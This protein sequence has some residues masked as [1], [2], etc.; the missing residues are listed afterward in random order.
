VIAAGCDGTDST[1]PNVVGFSSDE[2]DPCSWGDAGL[3][4][5]SVPIVLAAGG[6][7][8][9][10]PTALRTVF[11]NPFHERV[12][13]SFSL[14]RD[15]NV[16]VRVFDVHGRLVRDLNDR[17]VPAGS[18]VIAWDGRGGSGLRA[19]AGIYFVRFEA[20]DATIVKKLVRLTR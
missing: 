12:S 2:T 8:S 18:H 15:E 6:G 5:G 11:P 4:T 7:A 16:R 1:V 9:S 14:A 13:V 10:S 17:V 3:C 20:G 19:A